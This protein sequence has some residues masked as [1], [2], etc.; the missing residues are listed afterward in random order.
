MAK[1]K[2]KFYLALDQEMPKDKEKFQEKL[3]MTYVNGIKPIEYHEDTI[4]DTRDNSVVQ[5]IILLK[6]EERWKGAAKRF[7]RKCGFERLN[8]KV[9]NLPVLG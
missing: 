8:M 6:C 2:F 4:V 1:E 5:T 3:T 9:D 7:F